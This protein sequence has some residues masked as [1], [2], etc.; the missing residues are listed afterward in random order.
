MDAALV[1]HGIGTVNEAVHIGNQT[2][3]TV[4][5]MA[6]IN[7]EADFSW[8]NQAAAL[9]N[10]RSM[11]TGVNEIVSY[12]S[13][14]EV[15]ASW[16]TDIRTKI[17]NWRTQFTSAYTFTGS[18]ATGTIIKAVHLNELFTAMALTSPNYTVGQSN[19]KRCKWNDNP[20]GTFEGGRV[21]T[22]ATGGFGFNAW[23][24]KLN[25]SGT[26]NPDRLERIRL[27]FSFSLSSTTVNALP[28][29]ATITLHIG[30]GNYDMS[31]ESFDPVI[32]CSATDDNSYASGWEFHNNTHVGTGDSSIG[33]Y[34]DQN[35]D[36]TPVIGAYTGSHMSLV[37]GEDAEMTSSGGTGSSTHDAAVFYASGSAFVEVDWNLGF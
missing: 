18:P 15:P 22:S 36:I 7:T 13:G 28:S 11:Q 8:W 37:I 31:I 29:T 14:D 35:I 9:S 26:L 19:S 10:R 24:G 30:F 4:P 27:G 6:S 1:R 3:V 2:G 32:Y 21:Q 16:L 17:N 34:A 33:G 5:T 25:Q 23:Y 20:Y 12:L